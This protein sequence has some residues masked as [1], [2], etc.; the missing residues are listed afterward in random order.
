MGWLF[1]PR[2]GSRQELLNYLRSKD[3]WGDG[4]EIVKAQAVGNNHW[5]VGK[6]LSDGLLFIGLD[7]MR[8]SR[9]RYEGWGYKDLDERMGP[10]ET[11][12][13]VSYL[14]IVPDPG[15]YATEWR[16]KV[17]RNAATKASKKAAL[18]PGAVVNY[19]GV[20]YELLGKADSF[21]SNRRRG[22]RVLSK[23][24]GFEYRMSFR[25]LARAT[26]IK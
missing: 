22:W 18:K 6:R 9:D 15:G 4:Y 26:L 24:N 8:G 10:C 2:W 7:L 20:N 23:E 12:C 17:R 19:G 14:N 21:F 1:S 5:Y 25:Q 16:E 11:N 3:R 13:P